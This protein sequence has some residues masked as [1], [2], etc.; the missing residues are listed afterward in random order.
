MSSL[1]GNSQINIS[2]NGTKINLEE[3]VNKS[4]I[5]KLKES[6][7]LEKNA[8][9]KIFKGTV[10]C[11]GNIFNLYFVHDNNYTSRDH[12]KL[13][14]YAQNIFKMTLKFSPSLLKLYSKTKTFK[15]V[16]I[17]NSENLTTYHYWVNSEGTHGVMFGSIS[18]VY[19]MYNNT[20]DWIPSSQG[21]LHEL[22]H[23]LDSLYNWSLSNVKKWKELVNK[24]ADLFKKTEGLGNISGYTAEKYKNRPEELF[25]DV[26]N[27]YFLNEKLRKRLQKEFPEIYDYFEEKLRKAEN[28]IDSSYNQ[29]KSQQPISY[30]SPIMPNTVIDNNIKVQVRSYLT[31]EGL[32][33]KNIRDGDIKF[34]CRRFKISEEQLKSILGI[35][36]S[37]N[38]NTNNNQSSQNITQTISTTKT[39]KIGFWRRL[40][41]INGNSI[42]NN[43]GESF[44]MQTKYVAEKF[45]NDPILYNLALLSPINYILKTA[46]I[47]NGK[48]NYGINQGIFKKLKGTREFEQYVKI[49]AQRYGLTYSNTYKIMSMIDTTGVCS[50]AG[51]LTSMLI[52]HFRHNPAEFEK[53]FGFPLFKKTSNGY[54]ID[55]ASIL[56]DV[57]Y[58]INDKKNG[59]ILFKN[60]EVINTDTIKQIYL[61]DNP[62]VALGRYLKSKGLKIKAKKIYFYRGHHFNY[63]QILSKL[64]NI[65]FGNTYATFDF[66]A[67]SNKKDEKIQ[68]VNLYTNKTRILGGKDKHAIHRLTILEARDDG[69]V[70]VT[71]GGIWLIP[72]EEFVKKSI[73]YHILVYDLK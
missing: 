4:E 38:T 11:G 7:N 16:F 51:M 37:S 29:I 6:L 18:G 49:Y 73:D 20:S 28:K 27:V 66:Y 8:M 67:T 60:G 72:K 35:K 2:Q 69:L 59:G 26:G 24:Y 23:V 61:Y 43:F 57:Y 47:V 70:V 32:N 10:E 62:Q 42:T 48:A 41:G 1:K 36:I 34:I 22:T 44:N 50:Y 17:E 21:V 5:N 15:F 45:Q 63:S 56:F 33:A 19:V 65:N 13:E 14:E 12:K 54:V 52:S 64:K 68:L 46:N 25:A 40:F 31:S 53:H 55:E 58:F 3:V 9:V 30:A 71:W 39:P